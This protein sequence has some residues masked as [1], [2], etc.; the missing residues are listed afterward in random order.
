MSAIGGFSDSDHSASLLRGLTTGLPWS[1][2]TRTCVQHCCGQPSV[3]AAALVTVNTDGSLL[4]DSGRSIGHGNVSL[5]RT[6]V[7]RSFGTILNRQSILEL[8]SGLG[9]FSGLTVQLF[10]WPDLGAVLLIQQSSS[11]TRAEDS[12]GD[13]LQPVTRQ[14]LGRSTDR[15][16]LFPDLS[17]LEAMAEYA[18]GAGHEINNPLASI[19][20][21]AQLLMKSDAS[22]E[23]RQALETIGA[24]AWRIRDMIGNSMLFARPPIPQGTTF[25]LIPALQE[26]M[27]ALSQTA[28]DSRVELHL[29]AQDE[30]VLLK[31][32]R[33]QISN[34]VAQLIR[35]SIQA[36]ASKNAPG[37]VEVEVRSDIEGVV[38]IVVRDDGPG[39]Q[40]ETVRRHLFTPFFSGRSAGRGLGFGLSLAWQIVRMHQGL[41]FHQTPSSGG[42]E[43]LI[44]LSRE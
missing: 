31:A 9:V 35:N 11:T 42:A 37:N 2:A 22:L 8:V 25:P 41:L 38:E 28:E 36:I 30:R 10:P 21:Q 20:G 3:A 40:T 29:S 1:D 33:S 27:G 14:L 26:L 12:F 4:I 43:F 7:D 13:F 32:D 39:L 5:S 6:I 24:Q 44:G 23:R 17:L 34:A 16:L 15:S 18:A 19:I